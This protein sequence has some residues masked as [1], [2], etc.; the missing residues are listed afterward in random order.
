MEEIENMIQ[1]RLQARKELNFAQA[2]TARASTDGSWH[3]SEDS[4]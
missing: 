1:Q 2:D 3:H 4:S